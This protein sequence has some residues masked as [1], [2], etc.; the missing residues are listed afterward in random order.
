MVMRVWDMLTTA[1]GTGANEDRVGACGTLAWVLDGATD[2]YGN[3]ALPAESDVQWLVDTVV[4]YLCEAGSASYRGSAADLLM[5]VA[6]AVAGEQARQGFPADRV[7]PACS[8]ALC[9]DQGSRYDVA[10]I[11]DT[12]IAIT[13]RVA[14]TLA[15]D[16]FDRR[17]AA[18]V[19]SGDEDRQRVEAAMHRRRLHTM[20]S[21]DAESVFSGHPDRRLSP[22]STAGAWSSVED[23]LLCTDGFARLITD[24]GR[25]ETWP[26][27]INDAHEHGLAYLEKLIRDAEALPEPAG[28][29]FK[30][31]DDIA[32]ILLSPEQADPS[33]DRLS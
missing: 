21:D 33:K 10:R 8:V 20:T 1:G 23:I 25:Y 27:V 6:A 7:P 9:V 31:S 29:R 17:E 5:E 2:L 14:A 22:H 18:A 3:A 32:V 12:T 15:T 11:G 24:Y 30:R 4:R 28:G 19:G 13:G 26:E 16:Y